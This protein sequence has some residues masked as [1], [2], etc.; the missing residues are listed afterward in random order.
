M[1]EY[2]TV[3][4]TFRTEVV[5][6]RSR[7]IATVCRTEN[8]D[9][10]NAFI[11]SIK[12]EFP[13]ATHHPYAFITE[14]GGYAKS[15]DDGEPSGT[16]GLPV[17]EAIKGAG[18]VDACVVVT[19]Y[20]GGVKLGTGGLVRA[21]GGAASAAIKG[22][23]TIKRCLCR[24]CSVKLPYDKQNLFPKIT[25]EIGK[26][27]NVDYLDRIV[28]DFVIKKSSFDGFSASFKDALK[29][30]IDITVKGEDY[31]DV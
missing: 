22:A 7:F 16:G 30:K 26:I 23:G 25:S 8:A 28:F 21:Y 10:A 6:E 19:R 20:F 11:E 2:L 4:Q 3:K 31:F 1:E 29:G 14:R 17:L 18:I 15:S 13:D 27:L 5:I 9:Q 12:K 24:I